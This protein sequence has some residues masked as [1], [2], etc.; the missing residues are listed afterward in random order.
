VKILFQ[1]IYFFEKKFR[2]IFSKNIFFHKHFF[3]IIS[4]KICFTKF[5]FQIFISQFFQKKVFETKNFKKIGK[6][7]K[8]VF[9]EK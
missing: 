1:K 6:K 3:E 7:F 9:F 8:K 2:I 4:P 5:I